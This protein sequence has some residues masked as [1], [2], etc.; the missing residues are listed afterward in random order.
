MIDHRL[1]FVNIAMSL[2]ILTLSGD[3]IASYDFL[4]P[5]L[6]R[7]LLSEMN[8]V[9]EVD[10]IT[11]EKQDQRQQQYQ[12]DKQEKLINLCRLVALSVNAFV[13]PATKEN[14]EVQGS[15]SGDDSISKQ[16][17][18]RGIRIISLDMGMNR[19]SRSPRNSTDNTRLTYSTRSIGSKINAAYISA[20]NVIVVM[21]PPPTASLISSS[22]YYR[23][24]VECLLKVNVYHIA[25]LLDCF[26]RS[27]LLN[28][29]KLVDEMAQERANKS[30]G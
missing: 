29:S 1:I 23:S 11:N 16:G 22:F 30:T 4:S 26:Y 3:I 13:V 2:Y 7:S 17:V 8:A 9:V 19:A 24:R 10:N 12:I 28:V 6:S 21:T 14:R 18:K 15:G 5:S 20:A 25:H 27:S